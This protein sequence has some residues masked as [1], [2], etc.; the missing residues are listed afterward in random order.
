LPKLYWPTGDKKSLLKHS[1]LKSLPRKNKNFA[2][3]LKKRLIT[4]DITVLAKS[5][6]INAQE[7]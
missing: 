5:N 7:A 1:A 2:H 4:L 6:V 3:I